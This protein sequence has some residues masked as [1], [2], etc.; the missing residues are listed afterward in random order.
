MHPAF[1][2]ISKN[3]PRTIHS[4]NIQLLNLVSSFPSNY[5]TTMKV[6]TS[7]FA[8]ALALTSVNAAVCLSSTLQSN[9]PSPASRFS[10]IEVQK[11]T[12]EIQTRLKTNKPPSVLHRRQHRSKLLLGRKIQR[13]CVQQTRRLHHRSR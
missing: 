10:T 12:N 7:I 4:H 9:F 3:Q 13:R 1:I 2:A 8:F 5:Q 11:R 6:A